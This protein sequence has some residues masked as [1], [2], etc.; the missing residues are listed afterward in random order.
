ME[1]KTKSQRNY[2]YHQGYFLTLVLAAAFLT[3][4]LTVF[5]AAVFL[6]AGFLTAF[7]IAFDFGAFLAAG[8]LVAVFLT[9]AALAIKSQYEKIQK[10]VESL[11]FLKICSSE[12]QEEVVLDPLVALDGS[13]SFQ[14]TRE[15]ANSEVTLTHF[16]KLNYVKL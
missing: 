5:L 16:D 14:D 6:A 4:L 8:L 9:A 1:S 11:F 12:R 15:Q 13:N 2:E 3:V 7:L 10:R